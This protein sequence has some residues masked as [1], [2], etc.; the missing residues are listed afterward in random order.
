MESK[1]AKVTPK[2]K[3]STKKKVDE[4]KSASTSRTAVI[5]QLFNK[6]TT[7]F[8]HQPSKR[9]PSPPK[10]KFS[11]ISFHF[12]LTQFLFSIT[13]DESSFETPVRSKSLTID[14]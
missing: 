14:R 5:Q 3:P 8:A 10:K 9:T 2:R 11:P 13:I 1:K 6:T 4:D 7:D 12:I